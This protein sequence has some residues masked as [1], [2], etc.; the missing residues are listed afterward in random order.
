MLF[1]H[2]KGAFTGADKT[3]EGL[4]KQADRGTLFLDEVGELPIAVQKTFLRVLQERR[5]RPV[6]GKEE[7]ESNFRLIAA[8]NRDLDEMVQKGKF[9]NDLLFRLRSL[10]IDLPPLKNMR[11]DIKDLAIFYINRFCDRYGIATKGISPEFLEKLT[12]YSWPGNVRELINALE[13]ALS[14]AQNEPTLFPIHLPTHIKVKLA[15]ASV[16]M[17]APINAG[18]NRAPESFD[19]FSNLKLLLET[20][21]RQYLQD[22]MTFTKGNIKETCRISGLSRSRLY[23]RLKKHKIPSYD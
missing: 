7:M 17:P 3:K 2:E 22:L 19:S 21:E 12:S 1:G 10:T 23:D 18:P 13:K 15:R 5:F 16:E 6:G 8:S 11:K 14:S 9:R 4:I 20:T